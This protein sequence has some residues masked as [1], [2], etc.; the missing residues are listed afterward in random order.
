[1][2]TNGEP[3]SSDLQTKCTPKAEAV[4]HLFAVVGLK[5]LTEE[6]GNVH[7]NSLRCAKSSPFWLVAS[8]RQNR[9]MDL[10][11]EMSSLPVDSQRVVSVILIQAVIQNETG[12]WLWTLKAEYTCGI[13]VTKGL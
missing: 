5:V 7:K 13:L 10:L 3:R 11:S 4:F 9:W 12:A 6:D 2:L 8:S 1:M